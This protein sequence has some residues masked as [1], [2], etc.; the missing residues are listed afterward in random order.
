MD[1]TRNERCKVFWERLIGD[2]DRLLFLERQDVL[3]KFEVQFGSAFTMMNEAMAG[4]TYR[5]NRFIDEA[6]QQMLG[7]AP[8]SAVRLW[9]PF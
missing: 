7:W 1:E 6:R 8:T 3:L 9:R 4:G 2:L 5:T